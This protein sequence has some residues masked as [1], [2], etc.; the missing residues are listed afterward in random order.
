LFVGLGFVLGWLSPPDWAQTTIDSG[1]RA[2]HAEGGSGPHPAA[3]ENTGRGITARAP[4]SSG[5]KGRRPSSSS[6][7]SP[8]LQICCSARASPNLLL[9]LCCSTS[10][11]RS[12]GGEMTVEK[13]DATLADFGAHFERLF[14]SPDAA[15][16]GKVKLLLFLAD[17]EPGSSLTWCPG[18]TPLPWHWQ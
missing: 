16:D 18:K 1:S 11:S 6:V 7:P 17:R 14:A 8:D 15:S 4:V 5:D 9:L 2:R 10:R 13:V 12:R 3:C